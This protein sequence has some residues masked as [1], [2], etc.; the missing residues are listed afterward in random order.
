MSGLSHLSSTL[1]WN[2]NRGDDLLVNTQGE[3][4]GSLG[5]QNCSCSSL[6]DQGHLIK[7]DTHQTPET[8][9]PLQAGFENLERGYVRQGD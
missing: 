9:A 8:R 5:L 7:T 4:R 2:T 1:G 6:D 3:L